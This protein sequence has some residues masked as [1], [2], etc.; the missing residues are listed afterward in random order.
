MDYQVGQVGRVIVIR[1]GEGEDIYE[2][3]ETLARRENIKAAAV[4][5]VGGL[6]RAEVVV[7]PKQEKPRIVGNFKTFDGPGEVLGVGTIYWDEDQPRLHM[8]SAMGKGNRTIVGC[9]RGGA[10][11]FLVLEVTIIEITGVDARRKLDENSGLK[12]LKLA[13]TKRVNNNSA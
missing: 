13:E 3:I 4:M 5:I 6:R 2:C 12:L 7:G 11:T 9:P 10:K 1:L 8:H